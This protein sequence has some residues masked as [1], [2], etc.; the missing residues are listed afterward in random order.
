MIEI[1][2]TCQIQVLGATFNGIN[3]ICRHAFNHEA[4]DGV[5]VGVDCKRYPCFDSYDSQ[6]ENRYYCNFVFAKTQSEIEEKLSVL[7]LLP[8]GDNYNK[9]SC[10]L[11]PMI[12]WA[13]DED[14]PMAI[15]SADNFK[16][17]KTFES[18]IDSGQILQSP[19][20]RLRQKIVDIIIDPAE[21]GSY[22]F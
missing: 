5:F 2:K 6:F 15:I 7:S 13:G 11:S 1:K 14:S 19:I 4:K 21:D 16:F 3:D 22:Y 8:A 9:L 12:Y 20:S 17:G 10:S 18:I